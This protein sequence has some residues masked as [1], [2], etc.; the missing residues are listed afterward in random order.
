M[1][2]IKYFSFLHNH[3]DFLKKIKKTK[4][5]NYWINLIPAHH[6]LKLE[7]S[8]SFRRGYKTT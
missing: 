7:T 2:G 1:K 5:V 3:I 4:L 8:W 6:W